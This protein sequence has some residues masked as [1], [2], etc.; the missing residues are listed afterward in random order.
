MDADRMDK[1]FDIEEELAVLN[2][3]PRHRLLAL[4]AEAGAQAV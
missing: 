1:S 3:N 4:L 2:R